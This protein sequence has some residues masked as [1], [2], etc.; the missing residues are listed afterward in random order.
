[1]RTRYHDYFYERY[2]GYFSSNY[3][4][5]QALLRLSPTLIDFPVKQD[6]FSLLPAR[7]KERE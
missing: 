4:I 1:M 7:I 3:Q 5:N 6:P 2:T